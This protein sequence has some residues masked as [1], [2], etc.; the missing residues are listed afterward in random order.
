M[1]FFVDVFGK[2]LQSAD[3]PVDTSEVLSGKKVGLYFSAHWCPP[4]RGFTPQLAKAYTTT[5]REKG[6]EVVFVSSD[7]EES[8]FQ[9]YF[10][11]MPWLA[12]PFAEREKKAALSKK[13]KVN[14]IPTLVILDSDGTL[15]T[16]EGRSAVSKDPSGAEFPWRPKQLK[17]ILGQE[18]LGPQGELL[19]RK[20]VDGKVLGLYFSAHWCGPCRHFTPQLAEWYK[21]VSP[22]LPDFQIIFI[23]SDRTEEDFK[24][25]FAEMP[26]LAVPYSDRKQKEELSEHFQV[27]GIPTLVFVDQQLNLITKNGR[28]IPD[29]DPEGKKFPW[30]PKPVKDVSQ[31]TEDLQENPSLVVFMESS[32]DAARQAVEDALT[33]L[34]KEFA[35]RAKAGENELLFFIGGPSSAGILSQLRRLSGLPT[36]KHHHPLTKTEGRPSWYCDGCRK[37]GEGAA[38]YNCKEC[39]FDYCEDCN[40]KAADVS[41]PAAGVF[42]D[43]GQGRYYNATGVDFTSTESVKD[44]ADKFYRGAVESTSFS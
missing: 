5:L 40:T 26:W 22:S 44:I 33:P 32:D 27:S 17:E 9:S 7:K 8:E 43:F 11:T 20:A 35:Q 18:F 6:L 21:K 25:Y 37:D 39:N 29:S 34:A 19:D 28:G 13:F 4:C 10:K 12:L 2:K 42:F 16:L 3:G 15:I 38:A 14:G 36:A 31:D 1:A 30:L 41:G 23:S 24:N